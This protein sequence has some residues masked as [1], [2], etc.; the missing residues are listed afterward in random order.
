M[1]LLG[2]RFVG[3]LQVMAGLQ[4]APAL[5]PGTPARPF[6]ETGAELDTEKKGAMGIFVVTDPKFRVRAGAIAIPASA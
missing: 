3:F 1:R 5:D 2:G 4:V 6:G